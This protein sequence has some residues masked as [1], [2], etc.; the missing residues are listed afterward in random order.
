MPGELAYF[1][2]EKINGGTDVSVSGAS[3]AQWD[4]TLIFQK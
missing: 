1:S 4:W 3:M 2:F